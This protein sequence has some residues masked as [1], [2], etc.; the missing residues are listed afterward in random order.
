MRKEAKP[1]FILLGIG[2]LLLSFY[3]FITPISYLPITIPFEDQLYRLGFIGLYLSTFSLGII[4]LMDEDKLV[5]VLGGLIILSPLIALIPNYAISEW[6]EVI[7]IFTVVDGLFIMVKSVLKSNRFPL[8]LT[9]FVIIFNEIEGL[10]EQ[11]FHNFVYTSFLTLLYL[12]IISGFILLLYNLKLKRLLISIGLG[13]L[14]MG[15]YLPLFFLTLHNRFLEMIF[16]LVFPAVYGITISNPYNTP[17]LILAYSLVL[18]LSVALAV[19]IDLYTGLGFY[20]IETTT[21]LGLTG[22]HYYIYMVFPIM[23]FYFMNLKRVTFAKKFRN[24]LNH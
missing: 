23:G 7:E 17:L 19:N 2:A 4:G 18:F 21:F 14:A 20:M 6:W 9:L 10:D 13:G 24:V 16:A 15:I 5:R 12:T 22:F 11:I 8:I 1:F 3:Q